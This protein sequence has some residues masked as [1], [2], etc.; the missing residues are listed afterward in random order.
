[1]APVKKDELH[2][3]FKQINGTN[4]K[5]EV[6]PYFSLD[7]FEK[8]GKDKTFRNK[9]TKKIC[10]T[11]FFMPIILKFKKMSNFIENY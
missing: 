1:M 2:Q 3:Y 5:R 10:P 9:L 8:L 4:D 7:Q 6:T 11:I